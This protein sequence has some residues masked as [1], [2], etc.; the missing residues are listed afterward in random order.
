MSSS[1][2]HDEL[3]HQFRKAKLKM[4]DGSWVV[5]EK[6]WKRCLPLAGDIF[7]SDSCVLAAIH[8][9]IVECKF[10]LSEALPKREDAEKVS[11]AQCGFIWLGS[12]L[13][14]VVALSQPCLFGQIIIF[15]CRSLRRRGR[16]CMK[17]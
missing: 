15:F 4:W 5:A 12:P 17:G 11:V 13:C 7:G 1:D 14:V 16:L 2:K 6:A 9:E 3:T 8:F 10:S